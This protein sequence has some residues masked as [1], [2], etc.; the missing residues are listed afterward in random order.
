[1]NKGMKNLGI[2]IGERYIKLVCIEHREEEAYLNAHGIFS[3]ENFHQL[4]K[5]L[6]EPIFKKANIR[7]SLN[8]PDLVTQR[9]EISIQEKE[10]Y[11]AAIGFRLENILR[12]SLSSYQLI[13]QLIHEDDKNAHYIVFAL[14]KG[15]LKAYQN[16]L[17]QLGIKKYQLL[18]P[19][20]SASYLA[21]KKNYS[22]KEDTVCGL[23]DIGES[24][25][26]FSVF[27]GRGILYHMNLD[28]M[29]GSYLTFLN[30]LWSN[31]N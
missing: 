25:T 13:Y 29:A 19:E 28:Q 20:L 22:I 24:K 27:S 21:F 26:T 11:K 1:M 23:I 14:D 12:N 15:K 7:V 8:D 18:E 2:D 16:F 5:V 30:N 10:D 17:K 9:V 4:K 31:D 3:A 6:K